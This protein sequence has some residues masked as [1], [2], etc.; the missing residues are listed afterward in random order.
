MTYNIDLFLQG[1]FQTEVETFEEVSNNRG[2]IVLKVRTHNKDF[3]VKYSSKLLNNDEDYNNSELIQNEAIFLS[4]NS[5]ISNNLYVSS[6]DFKEITYLVTKWCQLKPSNK[7][8]RE[9][10]PKE[11]VKHLVRIIEQ[12][13]ILHTKGFV[14]GDI[15][16][17]HVLLSDNKIQLIDY[18]LTHKILSDFGYAGGMIHFNSPEICLQIL[19]SKKP[20]I[21]NLQS[22]IY[23]I[24]VLAFFLIYKKLPY[25]YVNN[26]I[27]SEILKSIANF[28]FSYPTISIPEYENTNRFILSC[29]QRDPKLRPLSLINALQSFF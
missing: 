20:I 28:N 11:S 10:A 4:N 9:L 27:K 14:H 8:F 25:E 29:L 19:Q 18:A 24:G 23:S 3:A 16:P 17:K 1:I 13:S 12:F 26:G 6:G 2:S 5:E 21:Y 7:F 15:Q 22:E